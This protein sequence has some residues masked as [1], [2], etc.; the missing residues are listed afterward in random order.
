M[1]GLKMNILRGGDS[2]Q[3]KGERA[4]LL[5]EQAKVLETWVMKFDF[6]KK[7]GE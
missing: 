2:E 5:L 7:L 3:A 1:E 6:T 4:K